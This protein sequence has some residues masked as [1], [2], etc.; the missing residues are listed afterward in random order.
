MK[1]RGLSVDVGTK[2]LGLYVE[3]FDVAVLQALPKVKQRYDS[4]THL[5]TD[6]FKKLLHS[7]YKEGKTIKYE[8]LDFKREN[9]SCKDHQVF[10]NLTEY[11]DNNLDL[12]DT[13]SFVVIERQHKKNYTAQKVEHFIYAYFTIKYGGFKIVTDISATR[14]TQVLGAPKK[15]EKPQRKKWAINEAQGVFEIRDDMHSLAKLL[16]G[17]KKDDLGDAAIQ[18]QVFKLLVF[19]DHKL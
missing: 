9:E 15:M 6:S 18:L 3:E 1:I 16:K 8:L 13:C 17:P 2:N 10:L 14:K 7:V 12:W 4:A 19:I 5:P 11:L